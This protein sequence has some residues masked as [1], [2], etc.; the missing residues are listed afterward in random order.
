VSAPLRGRARSCVFLGYHSVTEDGPPYLSLRPDTFERQ[1]DLLV[2]AGFRAGTRTTLTRIAAGEALRGRHAFITFDDGF[3]DTVTTALP[4]MSRR[5]LTGM[6]FVLP[7]HLEGGAPLDWPEVAGEAAR[8]PSLMRSMDWSMLESLIEAGWE[9]GSHTMSHARLPSLPDEALAQELLDSRRAVESRLGRCDL[10]AYPF[11]DWD[12]RVAEAATAAGYS[13][14]F[15]LPFGG[16]ASA[17]AMS[18]PRVT[19]D[20]RDASWRFR[21]KLSGVGRAALFSPLRP[22]VRRALGKRPHSHAE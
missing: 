1:L 15:T 4:L 10:L 11:G 12:D 2:G 16:Q 21:A 14:A 3:A 9:V 19:I 17:T 5:A 8:R 22:A 6:V 13:F 18:I 20:D 7:G